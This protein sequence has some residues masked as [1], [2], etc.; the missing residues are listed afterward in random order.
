[1]LPENHLMIYEEEAERL[2]MKDG[3]IE[4]FNFSCEYSTSEGRYFMGKFVKNIV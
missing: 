1:M 2:D 4:E 3:I